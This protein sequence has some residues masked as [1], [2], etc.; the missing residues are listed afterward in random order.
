LTRSLKFT[1]REIAYSAGVDAQLADFY[2]LTLT[3]ALPVVV[4]RPGKIRADYDGL[5]SLTWNQ[6]VRF[7]ISLDSDLFVR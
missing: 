3:L 1:S 2:G 4:K 7:L 5:R 6:N